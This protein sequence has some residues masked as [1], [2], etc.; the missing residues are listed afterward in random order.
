MKK[1]LFL[2]GNGFDIAH[3]LPTK[4][5]P[6]F[7]I[8]AQANESIP[9]IWDLYQTRNSDIWSDFENSLA[10]PDFNELQEIF[11]SYSPDYSSDRESDRNSII[12]QAIIS[13]N[14]QKTLYEF[15]TKAENE[16]KKR[17]PIPMFENWFNPCSFFINFNYTHTLEIIYEIHEDHI[18]HIHGEVGVNDLILGYPD[19]EF[20]PEMY[21]YD[22][23]MR[24]RQ[25]SS[26]DIIDYIDSLDDYYVKVAFKTLYEKVK[27]F[28][29]HTNINLINNFINTKEIDEI[30]VIGHAYK[31]DFKYY[32]WL[33]KRFPLVKWTMYY[34]N[35]EDKIA[36]SNLAENLR[37]DYGLKQFK[38]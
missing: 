14:L 21:F 37:I 33:K 8:I 13:G 34:Y 25:S 5:N 12:I 38:S 30:I 24:G 18:L 31:T 9:Y 10:Y 36:A 23:R 7:K 1:N 26:I 32:E 2:I 27:G 4:F 16:I 15:A 35:N 22:I 11:D 20:N 6:D 28:S 17:S 29:K 19:G 3:G